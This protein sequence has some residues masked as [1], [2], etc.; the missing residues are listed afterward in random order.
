VE[1]I[2]LENILESFSACLAFENGMDIET[3]RSITTWLEN[4]GALDYDVLRETYAEPRPSLSL[5]VGAANDV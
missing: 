2:N 3:A 4:E 5:V 1:E